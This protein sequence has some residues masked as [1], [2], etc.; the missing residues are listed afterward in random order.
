MNFNALLGMA[1]TNI[2]GVAAVA[3]IIFILF[4]LYCR[5]RNKDS[6]RQGYEWALEVHS[7]TATRDDK[8]LM[9]EVVVL[10]ESDPTP[11][12]RDG[13]RDCLE[14]HELLLSERDCEEIHR[15]SIEN[16]VRSLRLFYLVPMLGVIWI[17]LKLI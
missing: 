8:R 16:A 3:L 12:W 17:V 14:A 2:L 13:Y 1:V 5:S 9:S 6:Y 15:H 11:S 10:A 4:R 7:L